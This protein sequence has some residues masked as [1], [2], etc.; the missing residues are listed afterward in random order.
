MPVQIPISKL[1][2][3]CNSFKNPPWN[4]VKSLSKEEILKAVENKKFNTKPECRTRQ[5]HIKR[6][7][8]L[9]YE[10]WQDPVDIDV[11]VPILGC[12]PDWFIQ[13]GNHRVVAAIVREDETIL[14]NV[15]GQLDYAFDLFGVDCTEKE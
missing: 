7:A 14:A 4:E 8:Y 9:I 5:D 13:D 1:L 2:E 12:F 3:V 15:G 11:G 10:G 6:I